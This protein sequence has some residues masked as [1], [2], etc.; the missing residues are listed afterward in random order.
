MSTTF[1]TC[2]EAFGA[3]FVTT[4][5]LRA[6]IS[7]IGALSR[8]RR[9]QSRTWFWQLAG[10]GLTSQHGPHK[11]SRFRELTLVS[12]IEINIRQ[13][14]SI[15]KSPQA[16]CDILWCDIMWHHIFI[17]EKR[18]TPCVRLMIHIHPHLFIDRPHL[19]NFWSTLLPNFRSA[20]CS[21]QHKNPLQVTIFPSTFSAG[22]RQKCGTSFLLVAD[23]PVG[24]RD[25]Q[26]LK[27]V[28]PQTC[29]I[30]SQEAWGS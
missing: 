27:E 10:H 15:L 17:L 14:L 23:G 7:G 16:S 8:R 20:V 19:S 24:I 1:K 25:V 18:C 12:K 21:F 4:H 29:L 30:M 5:G 2:Q 11:V 22:P 9:R 26:A 3:Q 6:V 28:Q 13:I